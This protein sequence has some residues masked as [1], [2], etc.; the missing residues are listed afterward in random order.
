MLQ[1]V[2]SL[3]AHRGYT[4]KDAIDESLEA[5]KKAI[6]EYPQDTRSYLAAA[7]LYR[8]SKN[9]SAAEQVLQKAV[10]IDPQDVTIRRQLGALLALKLVHHSQE[11]SSQS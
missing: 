9:Y 10:A 2:E 5:L 4:K 7:N 1:M 11:E 3:I 8:N 6:K